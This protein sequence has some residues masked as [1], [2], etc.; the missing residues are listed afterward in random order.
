MLVK[1]TDHK[2]K[3][4]WINPLY[5]KSLSI[6]KPGETQ[7]EVSGWSLKM[8]VRQ[9]IEELAL[10]INAAMPESV[11][12]FVAAEDEVRRQREAAQAAA[13]SG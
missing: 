9:D 4:V 11:S 13:A 8:R 2:G 3:D 1:L 10:T 6:K 7:V 12:A 5:V